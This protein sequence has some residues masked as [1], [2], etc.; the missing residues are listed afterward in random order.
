MNFNKILTNFLGAF[1]VSTFLLPIRVDAINISAPFTAGEQWIAGGTGWKSPYCYQ[2]GSYYGTG[3]H[4]N[5]DYYAI[6]FNGL[7]KGCTYIGNDAGRPILAIADGTVASI[8][9]DGQTGYGYSVVINHG[10]SYTSRYAHLKSDPRGYLSIGQQVKRG[11]QIGLNGST[12]L[13]TSEHLHFVLYKNGQSVLPSPMDGQSLLAHESGKTI[14]SYNN[15]STPPPTNTTF[16]APGLITPKS[17][18]TLD[19]APLVDFSWQ[20]VRYGNENNLQYRF[21]IFLPDQSSAVYSS[22]WNKNWTSFQKGFSSWNGT[23]HLRFAVQVKNSQNQILQSEVR[24][25]YLNFTPGKPKNL[26]PTNNTSTATTLTLSWQD[27]GDQD[28]YPNPTR[29]FKV[30]MYKDGALFRTSV[31]RPDTKWV[32]AVDKGTYQWEVCADDGQTQACSSKLTFKA[33]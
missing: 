6:D 7:Y 29:N 11:Q 10:N 12:G 21:H 20:D 2:S 17:K 4:T 32:I 22:A 19:K 3:Y 5:N 27:G 9:S 14:T 24:H 16:K 33:K 8:S 28:N 23:N 15:P 25:F 13:S 26:A 31:W 18:Q 30:L 1:I